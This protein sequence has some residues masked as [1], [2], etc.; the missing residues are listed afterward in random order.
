MIRK[1]SF[2]SENK[3]G[4]MPVQKLLLKMSLPAIASMLLQALYN[5]VDSVFVSRLGEDALAA[6]TLVNPMQLLLI[7]VGIGTGVGLNSLISRRLGE[8]RFQEANSAATHGV[9]LVL[10]NSLVFFLVGFFTSRPFYQWY[11]DDPGLV[12]MAVTYG[13]LVLC[14]SVFLFVQTT[15][16]KILQGTGN[17]IM[18]MISNM[19]G[20]ITNI[21]L[22]PILIF[23]LFGAPRLG[24]AG[25]AAA[26]V[27]GQ[28]V[29]AFTVTFYVVK[30][31]MDVSISFRSFCFSW[32]TIRDIYAVALPG[33]IMQAIPSFVAIILNQ[34]LIAFSVTAVSVMGVYFRLQSF[35]FMPV[36]GVTQGSMPIMGYN[37]GAR[38]RLRLMHALKLTIKAC[39]AI[40]VTAVIVFQLFPEQLLALFDASD[41]MLKMGVTAMRLLSLCFVP[42]AV[43]ISF[44][45]LFQALGH[46]IYSLLMTMT[47][48]V[49]VILPAAYF[50]SRAIGVT[51]VW[52]S[53]PI[54]EIFGFTVACL[55]FRKIYIEEIRG[56]PDGRD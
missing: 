38:N 5:V 51:G 21:V 3:M 6:V 44:A 45:T 42:A 2:M 25:A 30:H 13:R 1:E 26:T 31:K 43:A 36:F 14:M 46:G 27:I 7:S 41:N 19:T 52:A 29:G 50:L 47:R 16:E 8:K 17:M 48:Q 39:V 49:F 23:G 56:I 10:F 55:F 34:I 18:P 20:C 4:T 53:Y 40:M 15:F 9:L 35:A 32:K 28:A 54:A 11:S 12:N 24:V 33:M 22:D 37:F